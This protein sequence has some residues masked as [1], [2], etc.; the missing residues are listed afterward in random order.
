LKYLIV[1]SSLAII[2]YSCKK[3]EDPNPEFTPE[4]IP[5]NDSLKEYYSFKP[6][7]WWVYRDLSDN[8]RDSIIVSQNTAWTYSL[9]QTYNNT[10]KYYEQIDIKLYGATHE[11]DK[12]FLLTNQYRIEFNEWEGI[13][14]FGYDEN[15]DSTVS[16]F[17]R[18][19]Y[20]DSIQIQNVWYYDVAKTKIYTYYHS[21]CPIPDLDYYYI[22]KEFG[23]IKKEIANPIDSTYKIYELINKNIV[24]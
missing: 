16:D 6:G 21:C 19:A 15:T 14:V 2:L 4:I 10:T 8:S 9:Y 24:R 5:I 7:T 17:N 20:Y 18:V 3:E 1:I 12:Y 22:N 13:S 23:I 11:T